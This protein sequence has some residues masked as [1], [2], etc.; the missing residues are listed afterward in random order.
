MVDIPEVEVAVMMEVVMEVANVCYP[1]IWPLPWWFIKIPFIFAV[2]DTP[3]P[4][5]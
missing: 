5:N 3:I 2:S 4:Q 1:S